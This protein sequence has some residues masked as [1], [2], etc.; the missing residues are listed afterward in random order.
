[1]TITIPKKDWLDNDFIERLTERGDSIFLLL[2]LA[3][4]EGL[5]DAMADFMASPTG[6]KAVEDIR[7]QIEQLAADR[8][9]LEEIIRGSFSTIGEGVFPLFMEDVNICEALTHEQAERLKE[10]VK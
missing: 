3:K 5:R 1:M 6:V 10:V 7:E 2:A 9:M 4:L 8:D